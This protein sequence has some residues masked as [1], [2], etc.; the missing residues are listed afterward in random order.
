MVIFNDPD[1]DEYEEEELGAEYYLG[2]ELSD[3]YWIF[4]LIAKGDA[5]TYLK[6]FYETSRV[7]VFKTLAYTLTFA[8]EKSKI[9]RRI[10]NGRRY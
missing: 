10:R 3:N 1:D 5:G 8:K 7:D 9:E 2:E 6:L 4:K